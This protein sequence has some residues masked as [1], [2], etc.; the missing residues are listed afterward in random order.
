[1][2]CCSSDHLDDENP[3]CPTRADTRTDPGCAILEADGATAAG[4]CGALDGS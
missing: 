4:S 3:E 1:M 2:P